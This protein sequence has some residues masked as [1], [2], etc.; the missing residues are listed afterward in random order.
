MTP[1]LDGIGAI[2]RASHLEVLGGFHPD[3]SDG[4]PEGIATLILLGPREPGFWSAVTA[5]REFRDD[6][7]DPLDR[8]SLRTIGALAE[9]IG[10]L[11]YFPFGA[12]ARPFVS[13]ALRSG[14]AWV[15]EVGLLV[16]D[17]AGLLVS[18]RGAL[19]LRHRI[20]LP[21]PGARPCDTCAGKPCLAAC[22]VGALRSDGYDVAACRDYLHQPEGTRTCMAHGCTVRLSCP[23]SR[24]YPRDPAQS[25]HHMRYFA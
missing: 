11:P 18:Y 10:A 22:P 2:A 3:A 14:H 8:W 15:S 5:E 24:G 1:D 16:H 21:P 23:V 13:W 20:D 17:H 25:A 19:G 4:L 12:P 7:P 6:A 9:E